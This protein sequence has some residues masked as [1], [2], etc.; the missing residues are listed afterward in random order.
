MPGTMSFDKLS[1]P[2]VMPVRPGVQNRMAPTPAF[3]P[4]RGPG[5]KNPRM[6]VATRRAQRSTGKVNAPPLSV[7]P[8]NDKVPPPAPPPG[9]MQPPGN[10]KYR[11][12][13]GQG[14]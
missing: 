2:T 13:H 11:P 9:K 6:D 4:G 14:R 1:K 7:P 12:Y 5:T 8:L 3:M 10:S